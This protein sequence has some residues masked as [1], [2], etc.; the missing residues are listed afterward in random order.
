MEPHFFFFLLITLT[1]AIKCKMD[2]GH[3]V[4]GEVR[5]NNDEFSKRKGLFPTSKISQVKPWCKQ[6]GDEVL[7]K[8]NISGKGKFYEIPTWFIHFLFFHHHF[9]LPT[10]IRKHHTLDKNAGLPTLT[11]PPRSRQDLKS[12]W[13]LDPAQTNLSTTG[14]LVRSWAVDSWM[15][16]VE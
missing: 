5:K 16:S 4:N 3:R 7:C 10:S 12:E 6:I 9:F 15:Y 1:F 13:Q 14:I 11:T 8:S 2:K